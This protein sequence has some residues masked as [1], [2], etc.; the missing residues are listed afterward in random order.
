MRLERDPELFS[1]LRSL[2]AYR[3][4]LQENSTLVL[5][6]NSDLFRFLQNP[7]E[8]DI[9]SSRRAEDEPLEP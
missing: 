6:A 2:E 3:E 9:S 5:N 8:H 7:S 4:F 1:F